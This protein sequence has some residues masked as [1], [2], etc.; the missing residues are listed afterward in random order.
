MNS[1][2]DVLKK[3][4]AADGPMHL[5]R[6][7]EMCLTHP[8]FGYYVTR[9]P[10]GTKGDFITAPEVSQMFG[11]MI[12]LWAAMLWSDS[13]KPE[14]LN[15]IELGAGRGT[16]MADFI[17]GTVKVP[18]FH[19]ALHIAFVEKSPVLQD[20][21]KCSV[22]DAGFTRTPIWA[23]DIDGLDVDGMTFIIGNEFIDAL[24]IRQFEYT[25][26]GWM[27][28]CVGISENGALSM[29]LIAADTLFTA[30]LPKDAAIGD[31][32]ER[33]PARDHYMERIAALI[34]S[35]S[36]AALLIDYGH[37]TSDAKG[38]TFQAMHEHAFVDPLDNAGN[39]DLTSHVDF[40]RL[41]KIAKA[42]GCDVF[43]SA[44]QGEFLHKLGIGQRAQILVESAPE[45]GA[46]IYEAYKRLTDDDKMG[47]LFKVMPITSNIN[48]TPII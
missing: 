27:E 48:G 15:V 37:D 44:S 39:A 35:N 18:R 47:K 26:K 14:K 11:E 28:R 3:Y 33:S 23:E 36:G 38:D 20:K 42:A 30:H 9:D 22:G 40:Y 17:R 16:L 2:K 34:K 41:R 19:D 46:E 12:G 29:G 7:M 32:Y 1:L 31:I 6:Y 43:A 13:G 8:E 24:P 4:I 45:K 21:Q 5:A 10:F 25:D